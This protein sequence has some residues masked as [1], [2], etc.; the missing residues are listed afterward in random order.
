M[1]SSKPGLLK[2]AA[3]HLPA[4]AMPTLL[5]TPWPSGLDRIHGERT[6]RVDRELIQ[7]VLFALDGAILQDRL[8]HGCVPQCSPRPRPAAPTPQDRQPASP[9]RGLGII[10]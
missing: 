9:W 6:D 5:A 8:S 4:A 1:R 10:L 2:R 7:R 3:I